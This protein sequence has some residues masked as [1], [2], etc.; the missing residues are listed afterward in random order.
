VVPVISVEGGH[1]AT[2]ARRGEGVYA[3]ATRAMAHLRQAGVLFGAS[4]TV[5]NQNMR[6][7]TDPCCIRQL[8]ALGCRLVFFIDFVP[9]EPGS[10]V[11]ALST[12]E[13]IEMAGRI[14]ALRAALPGLYVA[15]PGDEE[16]YGGCL[17]A[18]RGFA[19]ISPEGR[20]EACPFAPY[21]D[22]SLK[23]TPLREALASRLLRKIREEP[24]HLSELSGGCALWARREWVA[25][26]LENPAGPDG[27]RAAN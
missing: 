19:H 5:T 8:N 9:V 3:G 20:L 7:V 21:A 10:E 16:R 2:D 17:A 27:P 24:E 22:T 23:D 15:L 14:E 11:L 13:R 12:Q 4:V 1:Q 25:S 18:G 6:A 26:L